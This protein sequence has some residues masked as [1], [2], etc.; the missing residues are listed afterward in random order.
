VKATSTSILLDTT[1][2]EMELEDDVNDILASIDS[3]EQEVL[4][5]EIHNRFI[6]KNMLAEI[7]FKKPFGTSQPKCN[8]I[9][10]Q[11]HPE[12]LKLVTFVKRLFLTC[13]NIFKE[14]NMDSFQPGTSIPESVLAFFLKKN[15]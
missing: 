13:S 5:F 8:L 14:L 10:S 1:S 12:N 2:E 9:L 3:D 6:M 4:Q 11:L 15:V 7:A